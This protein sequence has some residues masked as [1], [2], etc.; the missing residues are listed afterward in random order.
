MIK[1]IL[2]KL[3]SRFKGIKIVRRVLFLKRPNLICIKSNFRRKNFSTNTISTK[4]DKNFFNK[5]TDA[6]MHSPT[7]TI[8]GDHEYPHNPF[9]VFRAEDIPRLI[10]RIAGQYP[11]PPH[12]CFTTHKKPSSESKRVV[13]DALQMVFGLQEARFFTRRRT[14]AGK[15]RFFELF[16]PENDEL[17]RLFVGI[18]V[19]VRVRL[20]FAGERVNV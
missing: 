20:C 16:V 17:L 19:F 1:V 6:S 12:N 4:F 2:Q 3:I 8:F 9:L 18:F 14:I 15:R 13:P 5:P 10:V 7:A 11:S